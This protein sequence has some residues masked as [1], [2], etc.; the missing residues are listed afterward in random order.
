MYFTALVLVMA[1][2]LGLANRASQYVQDGIDKTLRP[3]FSVNMDKQNGS[4]TLAGSD[5]NQ[6]SSNAV[7]RVAPGVVSVFG[8]K[9]ES[10]NFSPDYGSS[11]GTPLIPGLNFSFN[12][13][14]KPQM[15]YIRVSAGTGFFVN[16]GGYIITNKHV[17]SDVEGAYKVTLSDGTQKDASVI[18]RDP[19]KDVAVM[20]IDG[21]GYPA[22]VLGDSSGVK[23]GQDILSIGNA[24]GEFQNVVSEG[25]VKALHKDIVANGDNEES[26]KLENTI[27]STAQLYPGDSG[28]PL[29]DTNGKVVGLNAAAAVDRRNVSFSIPINDVIQVIKNNSAISDIIK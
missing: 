11:S 13:S 23:V 7:D 26:Q 9:S 2:G 28:G 24:F 12:F 18:Y 20:K 6:Q 17:V 14:K 16:S 10:K 3:K 29:F 15:D 4:Y 5:L 1:G 22:L 27:Q 19:N 25:Q 8:Y 21:Y